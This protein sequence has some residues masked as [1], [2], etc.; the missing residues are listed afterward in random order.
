M[1]K[2]CEINYWTSLNPYSTK[3][4]RLTNWTM[5]I[6][7]AD[8]DLCSSRRWGEGGSWLANH[9]I[10]YSFNGTSHRRL[11]QWYQ[12]RWSQNS[13]MPNIKTLPYSLTK[14]IT[15][16]Y[17]HT[18]FMVIM[19]AIAAW[20]ESCH[21]WITTNL[22]WSSLCL[23]SFEQGWALVRGKLNH[24]LQKGE[25]CNVWDCMEITTTK[26]HIKW[27]KCLFHITIP[28]LIWK[29]PLFEKHYAS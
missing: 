6:D 8:S 24:P 17:N 27:V 15:Y 29:T 11:N 18:L 20:E 16:D 1:Y 19:C 25:L 10:Y 5:E 21:T 28:S 13:E 26:K 14:H 3:D 9:V 7:W 4:I 22:F 23:L 2:L 12:N